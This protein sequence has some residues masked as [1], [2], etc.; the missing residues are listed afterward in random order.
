MRLRVRLGKALFWGVFFLVTCLG[1]GIGFVCWYITNSDTMAALIRAELPRY[2]PGS[3]FNVKRVHL[4]VMQGQI[5]L[6]DVTVLQ[7]IDETPFLAVRLP[8][9]WIKHDPRALLKKRFVAREVKVG[10]PTLRL[11]RRSDGTWNLQGLLADPWPGPPIKTPP[12]LIQNGTIELAGGAAGGTN[13]I[14]RDVALKIE[15]GEKKLLNFEGS[16]KGDAFDRLNLSGSIDLATGRIILKGDITRLAITETLRARLPAEVRPMAEKLGLTGGEVDVEAREVVYDPA[17]TPRL[18]YDVSAEVRSG[19][20]GC[21]SLPFT[22][23]DLSASISARDGVLW[24]EQA[25][26]YN[27]AT[28]VRAE[29]SRI[30]MGDPKH[31]P[32]S[33]QLSVTDLELDQ[34]LRDKTPPELDELWSLYSPR[35]R[36]SAA[37]NLLREREGGPLGYAWQVDCRDVA[38]LYKF[39]KYPLD[40]VRG[41]LRCRQK[42][43]ELDM[44]TLVGGRPLRAVGTIDNPG[45]DASVALEFEGDG[46]PIDQTLFDALPPD[47]RKVVS[48]FHP[49]G[50]VKGRAKVTRTKRVR[51][52]DPPEGIVKIDTW[53]DL[54]GRCSIR[55]DGL[56][57]PVDNLTGQLEFHP[58]L[59]IFKNM[60]GG[61][62]QAVITGSGMVKK[63]P[64]GKLRGG[65]DPLAVDLSLSAEK[66]PF[67]DQL[68]TA[69]PPA[70]QKTWGTLNPIGSSD[71]QA[72][73]QLSPGKPDRYHLV[74][75]PLPETLVGLSF[76]RAVKPGIDAGPTF[77]LRM[78]N[79]RGQFVFDNGPVEM[80]NVGFQFYGSPVEFAHGRVVVAD[81]GQFELR[82]ENVLARKFRLDQE[83]RKIMPP[84]MEKFARRFDDGR[85][86]PR[87]KGNLGLS[88]SGQPGQ[89]VHC[90]WDD[91]LVVFNDNTI[92]AGIP[93]EHL[94]GQLDHVRGYFNGDDLRVNGALSL[95]SVS[96]LG[97]QI[98]RLETPFHIGGGQASLD[99][100]KGTLLGGAVEGR[101]QVSLDVTPRYAARLAV[102]D[103]KLERYADTLHGKQ[104]F[105]GQVNGRL[106]LD[107]LGN[108]LRTL[109]GRGEAHIVN[110]ELGT[111]PTLL[112][113]VKAVQTLGLPA[114]GGGKAMFDS[115]DVALTISNGETTFHPIKLTG[116]PF[117]LVGEGSMDVQG[118]VDLLLKLVYG[119]DKLRVPLLSSAFREVGGQ[120]LVIHA[121]GP[122]SSL[123]FSPLP[124]PVFTDSLH[125][126]GG[127]LRTQR[128]DRTAP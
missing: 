31:M 124:L 14:L 18:K 97:Q 57:Y 10:Q 7:K 111:L 25:Q 23:N 73:I 95:D 42:H 2:L 113:L 86:I 66:L 37:V 26:G 116:N 58:D 55:W 74:I 112:Q 121:R 29:R 105:R 35:G 119:R 103:A 54:T 122:A 8:W 90:I 28:T 56:P 20:W 99:N 104:T 92:Q 88:W 9:L 11:R 117:S 53:L 98:T 39:F 110:G 47:I 22:I 24:I 84:V 87:I 33:L 48:E 120:L 65:G 19:V 41:K 72:E 45:P 44:V 93:L 106:E 4:G 125:S 81:S 15:P 40:H 30:V 50:A 34:R 109:Q 82:V 75:V 32:L 49:T 36:I 6:S 38:M 43:I 51:P 27:G 17:A 46:V 13:A 126:I 115:A 1:G 52:D 114:P 61:N 94:Q 16:A 127:S 107:G 12:I 91:A 60:R 118:N 3:V 59:W 101:F 83:L 96:L 68:R 77:K 71:V 89:P 108:D 128:T 102:N 67:D 70:W 64:G 69:L 85:E 21:P 78:E 76:S 63:L 123:R 100:L 62:G 79:V 80:H 5:T